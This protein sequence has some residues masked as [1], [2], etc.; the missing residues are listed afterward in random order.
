MRRG[1]LH[2]YLDTVS[3]SHNKEEQVGAMDRF[4]AVSRRTAEIAITEPSALV[5]HRF[6]NQFHNH[7]E[8]PY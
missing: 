8:G 7:G 1:Q 6:H 5:L 4:Q 3:R 2:L